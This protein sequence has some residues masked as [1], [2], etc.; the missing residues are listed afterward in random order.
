MRTCSRPTNRA[1]FLRKVTRGVKR[2]GSTQSARMSVHQRLHRSGFLHLHH[3]LHLRPH[4]PCLLWILHVPLKQKFKPV[5][6]LLTHNLSLG[7][8]I[9]PLYGFFTKVMSIIINWRSF[10][11]LT[12]KIAYST[13]AQIYILLGWSALLTV[14]MKALKKWHRSCVILLFSHLYTWSNSRCSHS[15]FLLVTLH[16]LG[17][18]L[19]SK[20]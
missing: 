1:L 2:S 18:R 7:S 17:K 3:R 16:C 10:L 13:C 15:G 14:Q 19:F 11:L 6:G 8:F 9:R 20:H 12:N 4:H 5:G